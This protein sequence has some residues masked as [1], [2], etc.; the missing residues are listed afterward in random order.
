MARKAL[1]DLGLWLITQYNST[2]PKKKNLYS[3]KLSVCSEPLPESLKYPVSGILKHT[4]ALSL[5]SHQ[6]VSSYWS[7]SSLARYDFLRAV[8]PDTPGW[9]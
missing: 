6:P 7:F 5:L 1:H 4:S 9:F 3:A 8:F 2:P